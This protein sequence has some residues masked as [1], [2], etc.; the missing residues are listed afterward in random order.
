MHLSSEGLKINWLNYKTGEKHIHFKMHADKQTAYITIEITH[1]DPAIQQ[2]YFEQFMQFKTMLHQMLGEQ[3]SWKLHT[4]GEHG[5]Q[6]SRIMK[7][8]H[9]KNVFNKEN[10]PGLISFF[11][12]RMITLD[13]F[14]NEVKYS[15]EAMR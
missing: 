8:L 10:W 14:W 9:G 12:P 7:E 3:W 11:K 13:A 6:V 4:A 2:I 5:K 15:F 1:P